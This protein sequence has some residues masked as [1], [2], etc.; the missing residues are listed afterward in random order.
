[1]FFLV[2]FFLVRGRP[3]K[4]SSLTFCQELFA[5]DTV[6]TPITCRLWIMRPR[7]FLSEGLQR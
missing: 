7:A 4:G 2:V 6:Q 1:M 3:R 5:N